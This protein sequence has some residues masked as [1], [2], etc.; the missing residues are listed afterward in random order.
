MNKEN[1]NSSKKTKEQVE[2]DGNAT[3]AGLLLLGL[4]FYGGYK[5]LKDT[6]PE[7]KVSLKDLE[8]SEIIKRILRE[9]LI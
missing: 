8:N 1:P 7:E 4:A 9:D 3:L 5:L 2:N 6:S